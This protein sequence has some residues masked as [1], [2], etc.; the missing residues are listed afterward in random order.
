MQSRQKAAGP[1]LSSADTRQNLADS[2]FA[3]C[4]I[5]TP[6]NARHAHH[7]PHLHVVAAYAQAHA[8][9]TAMAMHDVPLKVARRLRG[10]V[11]R[12]SG[13]HAICWPISKWVQ[14][15]ANQQTPSP[16]AGTS[17]PVWWCPKSRCRLKAN[18]L[19][20]LT[21][22]GDVKTLLLVLAM[23]TMPRKRGQR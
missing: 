18:L 14:R 8:R 6:G 1:R 5:R 10:Q 4:R 12:S 15:L 22:S 21:R 19:P 11:E 16:R 13:R 2:Y 17:S 7:L 3:G 20:R 23:D 9:R